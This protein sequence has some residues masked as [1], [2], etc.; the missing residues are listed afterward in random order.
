MEYGKVAGIDKP[1]SRIVF[2]TDRLGSRH[3]SWLPE[4]GREHSA[5]DLLD[6]SFE[7]GYNAFDTARIYR[8]SE[9]TLGAWVRRCRVRD[10]V[11]LI[12]KGCHPDRKG[13]PRL[14]AAAV[15]RDLHSSLK[16]LGTESIDLYLLHYDAPSA[17]VE[18][19]MEQ[20]N[21]H[22]E[23]GKIT[24]IGV[25]NWSHTRIDS[26]IEAAARLGL[27]SFAAASA[28]FSLAEWTRA[29]WPGAVTL[30]GKEQRSAREWYCAND[31]PVFAWSSLARGF[32][33]KPRSDF[34][35]AYFASEQNNRRLER[36]GVIAREYGVTVA[37]VA[38]AYVLSHRLRAFAV[39]GCTTTDKLT[40]NARALS[41]K[42]DDATL[43]WL[44]TGRLR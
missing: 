13:H 16:A 27:R 14:N 41:L 11:V 40:K 9:R 24:A 12:S 22:V 43:G 32:F 17:T 44:E 28:Q 26:A 31:L 6:R 21:R 20:L 39:V 34:A 5:F 8:D 3:L 29:P 42:L 33:S 35:A 4:H 18:P 23:Q 25:S 38:L 7:L 19:V 1:V 10:D 36:A 15:T 37:Q 2:G 30:G